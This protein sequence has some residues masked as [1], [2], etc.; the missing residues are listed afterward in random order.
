M[1]ETNRFFKISSIHS[2]NAFQTIHQ[3][4]SEVKSVARNDKTQNAQVLLLLNNAVRI[5]YL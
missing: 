5:D 2:N 3:L 4:Y 1:R